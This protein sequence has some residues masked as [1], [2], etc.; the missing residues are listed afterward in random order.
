MKLPRDISAQELI[1]S[2]QKPG[3]SI[4]RQKGSHITVPNHNPIKLGTLSSVIGDLAGHFGQT[5]E[6]IT[7]K[8]FG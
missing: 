2:L 6:E 4:S 3:Y 7:A 8:I 1:K 5:K